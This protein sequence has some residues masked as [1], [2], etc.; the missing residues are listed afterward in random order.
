MG[1]HDQNALMNRVQFPVKPGAATKFISNV[2]ATWLCIQLLYS[3]LTYVEYFM[4]Y[5][6]G[7]WTAG[8]TGEVEQDVQSSV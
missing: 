4:Y 8:G 6:V 5:K 1:G 3:G 7:F 2:S